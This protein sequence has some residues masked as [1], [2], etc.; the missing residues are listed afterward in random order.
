MKNLDRR[1][2]ILASAHCAI[3]QKM[4]NAQCR[5]AFFHLLGKLSASRNTARHIARKIRESIEYAIKK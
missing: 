3:N 2:P 4:T 1:S 5:L